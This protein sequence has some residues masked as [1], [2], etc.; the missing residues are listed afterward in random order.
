V[1]AWILILTLYNARFEVVQI[2]PVAATFDSEDA[3]WLAG[4]SASQL[5]DL[6]LTPQPPSARIAWQ[7]VP[8]SLGK[9]TPVKTAREVCAERDRAREQTG[10]AFREASRRAAEKTDRELGLRP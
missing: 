4:Y 2:V 7:C 3:C 9:A 1:T 10:D 6:N 8:S 5:E